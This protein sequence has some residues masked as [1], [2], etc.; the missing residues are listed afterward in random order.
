MLIM[1]MVIILP[2]F[3]L[4]LVLFRFSTARETGTGITLQQAWSNVSHAGP[5]ATTTPG[6]NDQ[7]YIGD[8]AG[9]NH[10]ITVHTNNQNAGSLVISGGSTLDVTTSTGHNFGALPNAQVLGNGRLRISSANSKA[11]FPAGD[12]GNFIRA[13]GGTVEYYTT[14]AQDFAIPEIFRKCWQDILIIIAVFIPEM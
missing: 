5:D 13:S 8:G 6:P 12:F 7:V 3:L 1:S 14:G 11:E 4:L 10:T 2:V 9:N